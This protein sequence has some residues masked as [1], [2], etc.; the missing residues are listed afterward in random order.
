MIAIYM[1]ILT[2]V[3]NFL[4]S[5]SS[6]M[7]HVS[8]LLPVSIDIAPIYNVRGLASVRTQFIHSITNKACVITT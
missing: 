3:T 2:A 4:L 8:F 1:N 6:K 5:N 7:L